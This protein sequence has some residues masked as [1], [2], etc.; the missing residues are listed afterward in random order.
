MYILAAERH[1]AICI[2]SPAD[3]SIGAGRN[4]LLSAPQTRA[5]FHPHQHRESVMTKPGLST[6]YTLYL[7]IWILSLRPPFALYG[8]HA[9]DGGTQTFVLDTGSVTLEEWDDF[10]YMNTYGLGCKELRTN[11]VDLFNVSEALT[12]QELQ[13]EDLFYIDVAFTSPQN[14]TRAQGFAA[15]K[16]SVLDS[17]RYLPYR[18]SEMAKVMDLEVPKNVTEEADKYRKYTIQAVSNASCPHVAE[19]YYPN[20]VR[21]SSQMDSIEI[22]LMMVL[23]LQAVPQNRFAVNTSDYLICQIDTS[24]VDMPWVFVKCCGKAI[25]SVYDRDF[26]RHYVKCKSPDDWRWTLSSLAVVLGSVAFLFWP[27]AVKYVPEDPYPRKK[28]KAHRAN[29]KTGDGLLMVD[30][31]RHFEMRKANARET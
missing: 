3:I 29:R 5:V 31:K 7:S 13:K 30:D 17:L 15:V 21:K 1:A 19:Y 16:M 24:Y 26:G 9:R 27:L 20:G 10:I 6:T 12:E 14:T 18:T 8:V 28:Q 23:L 11:I 22:S 2:L 4:T 25:P